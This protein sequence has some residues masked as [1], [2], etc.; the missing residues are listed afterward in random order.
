MRHKELRLSV[1]LLYPNTLLSPV[2]TDLAASSQPPYDVHILPDENRQAERLGNLFKGTRR[3][4]DVNLCGQNSKSAS[5]T[6][7]QVSGHNRSSKNIY[8][9]IFA[10]LQ[11]Y[12]STDG[13]SKQLFKIKLTIL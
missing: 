2:K 4:K 9:F 1:S 11:A 3:I 10:G 13:E 6:T 12:Y 7:A 8:S 5:L